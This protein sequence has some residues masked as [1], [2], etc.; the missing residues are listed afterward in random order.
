MV[1]LNQGQKITQVSLIVGEC[2]SQEAAR[3]FIRMHNLDVVIPEDL[4][5][6][7]QAEAEIIVKDGVKM[8]PEVSCEHW[9]QFTP[10]LDDY[11]YPLEDRIKMIGNLTS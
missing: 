1:S 2:T 10:E 5:N 11:R 9:S 7:I 8:A 6:A 3:K 4:A